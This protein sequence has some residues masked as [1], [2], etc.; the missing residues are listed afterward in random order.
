MTMMMTNLAE[1]KNLN[2]SDH[3]VQV[4]LFDRHSQ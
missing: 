2:I 4:F 3:A 1:K